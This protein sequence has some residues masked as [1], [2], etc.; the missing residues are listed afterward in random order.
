VTADKRD[1]VRQILGMV[2][3]GKV[4]TEEADRL[5]STLNKEGQTHQKCPWCAESIPSGA[6]V[7]P[8][9]RTSLRTET[10]VPV[11][12]APRSFR[13]LSGLSKF[14]VVYQFLICGTVLFWTCS[15]LLSPVGIQGLLAGL[16]IIS[17]I[18]M[19]KGNKLGWSL[20]VVWSSLQ[21]ITVVVGNTAHTPQ[22]FPIGSVTTTNGSGLGL[23]IVGIILLVLFIRAGKDWK[24]Q[25]TS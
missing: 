15:Y 19:C 2:E 16:G 6:E 13:D 8:E 3:S 4:S 24:T 10:G 17:A 1:E 20:G 7:C 5:L 25:Q 23:N 21:I 22:V 9:C 11:V 18:L 14:L 12:S